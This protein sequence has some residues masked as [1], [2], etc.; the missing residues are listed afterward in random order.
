[1]TARRPS[2]LKG[3]GGGN[4]CRKQN[5]DGCKKDSDCR[6]NDRCDG[7][8]R[9]LPWPAASPPGSSLSFPAGSP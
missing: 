1:M 2:P 3:Q 6:G 8:K 7:R 5:G 9:R 4:R